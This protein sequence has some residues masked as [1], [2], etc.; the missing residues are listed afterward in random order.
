VLDVDSDRLEDFSE[1][2]VVELEKVG[3]LLG[4][5]VI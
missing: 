2:D 5:L 4:R 1:L 3:V